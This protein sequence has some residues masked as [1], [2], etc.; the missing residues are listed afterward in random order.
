MGLEAWQNEAAN[1]HDD[2]FKDLAS[3]SRAA[4]GTLTAKFLPQVPG[5]CWFVLRWYLWHK[6]P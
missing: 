6:E 3:W 5:P 2:A 1:I 4:A